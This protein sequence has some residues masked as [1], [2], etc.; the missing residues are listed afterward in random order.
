MW[1]SRHR[2]TGRKSGKAE[3]SRDVDSDSAEVEGGMDDQSGKIELNRIY[4]I[5]RILNLELRNSGKAE[6]ES[7]IPLRASA[8]SA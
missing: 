3:K 2:R 1:K 8:T 5:L 4:R 6:E 7:K